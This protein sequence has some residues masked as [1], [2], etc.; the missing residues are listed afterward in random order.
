M[1]DEQLDAKVDGWQ[2][3]VRV[4]ECN[5]RVFVS[6]GRQPT[7]LCLVSSPRF[8]SSVESPLDSTCT[9]AGT[10]SRRSLPVVLVSSFCAQQLAHTSNDSNPDNTR[11]SLVLAFVASL[12]QSCLRP[13][14]VSIGHEHVGQHHS[15]S[16]DW[17][18][19]D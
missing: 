17:L 7:Q 11:W 2:L 10:T 14:W 16:H 13:L 19:D 12:K 1:Q 6:P 5:V 8:G 18:T 9:E 4:E 3:I 15:A